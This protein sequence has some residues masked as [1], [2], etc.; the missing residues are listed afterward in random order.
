MSEFN[1][2]EI[3]RELVWELSYSPHRCKPKFHVHLNDK[4][5]S[6]NQRV[7]Y[8]EDVEAAVLKYIEQF[9]EDSEGNIAYKSEEVEVIVWSDSINN[10]LESATEELEYQRER[11]E[12]EFD[13]D[14]HSSQL[15][16]GLSVQK[17]IDEE[18]NKILQLN[19]Q[20]QKF[21]VSGEYVPSYYIVRK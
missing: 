13:P 14:T 17:A 11:T 5:E 10:D 4:W 3:C 9:D 12:E 20:K 16:Y 21:T 7:V 8:A 15:E 19:E 18:L 1:R 6:E 2:C